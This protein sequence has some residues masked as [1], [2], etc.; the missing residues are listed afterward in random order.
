MI[1]TVGD[2]NMVFQVLKLNLK[3]RDIEHVSLCSK[4]IGRAYNTFLNDCEQLCKL[5]MLRHG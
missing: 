2:I 5:I 4:D 3:I 1:W